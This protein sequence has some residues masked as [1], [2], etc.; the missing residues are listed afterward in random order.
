MSKVS[1]N[2]LKLLPA[3]PPGVSEEAR[4]RPPKVGGEDLIDRGE[5]SVQFSPSLGAAPETILSNMMLAAPRRNLP[6]EEILELQRAA[7]RPLTLSELALAFPEARID[8]RGQTLSALAKRPIHLSWPDGTPLTLGVGTID[9]NGDIDLTP[10]FAAQLAQHNQHLVMHKGD[11][12]PIP[13]ELGLRNGQFSVRDPEHRRALEGLGLEQTKALTRFDMRDV[14]QLERVLGALG[15]DAKDERQIDLELKKAGVQVELSPEDR[16]RRV[17]C[18]RLDS[19]SNYI[20]LDDHLVNRVGGH[21]H[22]FQPTVYASAKVSTEHPDAVILGYK[23]FNHQSY[24]PQGGRIVGLLGKNKKSQH[25]GDMEMTFVKMNVE[26]HALE[27][28]L[29]G[30]HSYGELYQKDQVAQ[31]LRDTGLDAPAISI[32]YKAHGG[33]LARAEGRQ[34]YAGHGK[35]G[36]T[37]GDW[38]DHVLTEQFLGVADTPEGGKAVLIRRESIKLVLESDDQQVLNMKVRLGDQRDGLFGTGLFSRFDD[39]VRMDRFFGTR[40]FF[41]QERL[42][43]RS[44]S[45]RRG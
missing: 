21:N 17:V 39:G 27:S 7:G 34:T 42:N 33:D 28:I 9:K 1:S 22:L 5:R 40:W 45:G 4:T 20:D 29:T 2:G 41:E 43:T 26:T 12:A 11:E 8:G 19:K 31:N 38:K 37:P 23:R 15:V 25:E 44:S 18:A 36:V 3:P 32:S 30:R 35:D 16:L 10:V 14:S 24:A 6:T 13:L